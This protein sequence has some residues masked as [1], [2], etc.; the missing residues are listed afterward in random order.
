MTTKTQDSKKP[1]NLL[2]E[3]PI[4]RLED[5]ALGLGRALARQGVARVGERLSGAT[6]KLGDLAESAPGP[7]DVVKAAGAKSEAGHGR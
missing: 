3:L 2:T 7:K 1:N 6:D 5:E 4:D